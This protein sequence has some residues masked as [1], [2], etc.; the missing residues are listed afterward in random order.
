MKGSWL[1]LTKQA[2]DEKAQ[3]VC[4]MGFFEAILDD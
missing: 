4:T 3:A 2:S 1:F